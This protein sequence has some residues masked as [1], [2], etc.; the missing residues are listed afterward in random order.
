MCDVIKEIVERMPGV[1][2]ASKEYKDTIIKVEAFLEKGAE[3]V[4]RT[5]GAL[6]RAMVDEINDRLTKGHPPLVN[7]VSTKDAVA[8]LED[9]DQKLP[10]YL[11]HVLTAVFQN[12]RASSD[13]RSIAELA[14]IKIWLPQPIQASSSPRNFVSDWLRECNS[15][16]R[17]CLV[18]TENSL[19]AYNG[20]SSQTQSRSRQKDG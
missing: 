16:I 20:I 12:T 4:D 6:E 10:W 2:Q 7:E 3:H 15:R 5:L 11:Q 19:T 17:R 13:L 8:R 14:M 9:Y 1:E 18:P